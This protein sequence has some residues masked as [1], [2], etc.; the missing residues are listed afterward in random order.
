MVRAAPASPDSVL[1][2]FM[3]ARA[4]TVATRFT[5]KAYNC[6]ILLKGR[7]DCCHTFTQ[8]HSFT[9][10]THDDIEGGGEQQRAAAIEGGGG[11]EKGGRGG[12]GGGGRRR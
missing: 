1:I 10:H 4:T 5:K 11:G 3:A 8:K 6:N 9:R 2:S 7:K 12:G